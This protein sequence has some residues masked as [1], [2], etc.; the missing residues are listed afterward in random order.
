MLYEFD[1]QELATLLAA[2]Q[3][4]PAVSDQT[5]EQLMA[6]LRNQ[7]E[8]ALATLIKR[9]TTLLRTV[10]SR[11]VHNDADTDDTCQEV[12]LELWKRA[13]QYDPGKGKALGWMITV[14]RRRAID[15]VRRRQTYDRVEERMR[16]EREQDPL[17]T[18]S[19]GADD[20]A[21]DSDRAAMLREV[22]ATLPDAQR[23]VIQLAYYRGLSQRDIARE[24]GIPLGTIKTR[25]ELAIRK[26]RTAVLSLGGQAEWSYSQA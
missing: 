20:D 1:H 22:L 3:E 13:A 8:S 26:V 25:L 2:H 11:V 5:D 9:H 10:I 4:A 12:F 18:H 16:L 7:D 6:R 14:A 15:R 17:Q 24:T 21:N 19:R 23:E